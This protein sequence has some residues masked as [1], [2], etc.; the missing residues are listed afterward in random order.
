MQ[1]LRPPAGLR[2]SGKRLWASVVAEFDL[3]Q[4]EAELL[5]RACRTVDLMHTLDSI[6]RRDGPMLGDRVHPAVIER[7][8][9]ALTFSRL[10]ASLRLPDDE[11][12]RPQRRGSSRGVYPRAIVRP[13]SRL[14]A[15]P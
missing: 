4:H 13:A 1:T 12:R 10:I 2:R 15:L 3:E 7:R 14:R 11:D 6:I 5:E 9:Q 8:L